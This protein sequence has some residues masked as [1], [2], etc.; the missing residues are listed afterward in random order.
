MDLIPF[1]TKGDTF[2]VK[3]PTY[4]EL[5]SKVKKLEKEVREYMRKEKEFSEERKFVEYGHMKRTISL[6]RLNEELNKHCTKSI[7]F[8]YARFSFEM[9][10]AFKAKFAIPLPQ[11]LVSYWLIFSIGHKDRAKA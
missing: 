9:R 5:E 8:Y 4:N 11:V 7:T 2:M 3:N 10:T 1:M 6:M